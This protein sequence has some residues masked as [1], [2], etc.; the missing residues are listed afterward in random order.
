MRILS[1]KKKKK[2]PAENKEAEKVVVQAF[3][4]GSGDTELSTATYWED[5]FR[6]KRRFECLLG[7]AGFRSFFFFSSVLFSKAT[8]CVCV[9]M[10][11]YVL[12]SYVRLFSFNR[13]TPSQIIWF[14]P[15]RLPYCIV[16]FRNGRAVPFKNKEISP[17]RSF[18]LFFVYLTH[19]R[20]PVVLFLFLVKEKE[21][22]N[23]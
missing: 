1:K 2:E 16:F 6:S 13:Y 23:E 12:T 18:P 14:F 5:N 15:F 22:K 20:W 21:N 8:V 17:V 19:S 3:V 9:C 7:C 11:V 4:G 10:C